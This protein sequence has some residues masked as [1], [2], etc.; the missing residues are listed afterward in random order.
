MYVKSPGQA[1]GRLIEG[2]AIGEGSAFGELALMYSK[3]RAATIVAREDSSVWYI[4]RDTYHTITTY[5]RM[6]RSKKR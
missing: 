3:P 2:A 1:Q 5:F 6:V 4:D